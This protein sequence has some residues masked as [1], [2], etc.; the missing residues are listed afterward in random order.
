MMAGFV[1]FRIDSYSNMAATMNRK[2]R[3]EKALGNVADK[4]AIQ[5]R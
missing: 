2:F 4:I 3:G 5:L 1:S